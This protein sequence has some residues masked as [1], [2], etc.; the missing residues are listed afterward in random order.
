MVALSPAEAR[1]AA[2]AVSPAFSSAWSAAA[3]PLVTWSFCS[4]TSRPRPRGAPLVSAMPYAA[5]SAV[6]DVVSAFCAVPNCVL[7]T[8]SCFFASAWAVVMA[9]LALST[10]AF[11]GA[12]PVWVLATIRNFCAAEP[13]HVDSTA[14]LLLSNVGRC[15]HLP[16]AAFTS[17]PALR[18]SNFHCWALALPQSRIWI[19]VPSAELPFNTSR[20]FPE[21]GLRRV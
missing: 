4:P 14:S 20:H 3:A 8:A 10:S 15:R 7:S 6:S 5:L 9:A 18:T 13:L 2:S 19:F 17:G 1:V 21:F 12:L 16:D 11:A